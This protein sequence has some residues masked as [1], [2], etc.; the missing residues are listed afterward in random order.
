V[1]GRDEAR[2][3]KRSLSPNNVLSSLFSNKFLGN[4]KN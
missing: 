2:D 4:V 3:I 1:E